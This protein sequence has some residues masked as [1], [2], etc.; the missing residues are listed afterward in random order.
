MSE[1]KEP[2]GLDARTF[3]VPLDELA[4]TLA[5]KVQREGQKR[6]AGPP[7][8]IADI[9][10]LVRQA[11]R[12]YELFFYLNA[13]ERRKNDPHWNVAYSVAILPLVRCMIDCLYNIT[14]ILDDPVSKALQFRASGYKRS[15][16]ALDADEQRYGSLP[17]WDAFITKSRADLDFKLRVDSILIDAVRAAEDWPTL[18]KYLQ[19]K[20]ATLTPRQELLKKFTF[21]FWQEY[22][23]MAHATFQGLMPTA[24]FYAT[25]DV[26]HD[27]HA[28][29]EEY[30]ERLISLHLAR[31]A[32]ILMAMLTEL[33]AYFRFDGAHINERIHRMWDALLPVPEVKELYDERYEKLMKDRGIARDKEFVSI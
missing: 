20:G 30:S 23:A 19:Q 3:Q 15:L 14:A 22:S 29:L 17:E 18:G 11:S 12:I 28:Q 9:Y 13:D 6:F 7:F 5:L 1:D 10:Y 16:K 32:G 4:N 31:V 27:Q 33:Q 25:R 24:L 21:S 2:V 26:P 8:A